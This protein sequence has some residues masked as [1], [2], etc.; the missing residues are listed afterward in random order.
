MIV[1]ITNEPGIAAQ[2]QRIISIQN[3]LIAAC[4]DNVHYQK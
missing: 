1:M 2:T 4:F 3:G